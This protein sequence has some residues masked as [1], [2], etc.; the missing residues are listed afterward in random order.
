MAV[1]ELTNKINQVMSKTEQ[2]QSRGETPTTAEEA[3]QDIMNSF[4]WYIR[5]ECGK[6][7]N[8]RS[9]SQA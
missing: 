2:A 5:G 4:D 8:R 7:S 3:E 6:E 9:A 1:E